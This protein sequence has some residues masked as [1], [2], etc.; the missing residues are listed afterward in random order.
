MSR[1]KKI[2]YIVIHC[3]AGYGNRKSIEKFWKEKL[4]WNSPGY[5]R[6]IDSDGTIHKLSD[7]DKLTNGV[8][9]FNT[10]CIHIC[11]IGGVDPSNVNKAKDS[12]TPA[13]KTAIQTCIVESINWLDDNGKNI[14]EDLIVLGHR[15]FS[16]DKDG[17]GVIESWE[18][19][20]ECPSY[21]AI[22]EYQVFS[23]TNSDVS[24]PK[25]Q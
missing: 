6:L 3:S 24:L 8:K 7:F 13:Q 20:K 19:I 12:R 15:D 22:T 23:A 1:A 14:K 25:N 5:H 4:G 21:D 9:G 2:K 16:E 18:R 10:E 17:S 11:Y